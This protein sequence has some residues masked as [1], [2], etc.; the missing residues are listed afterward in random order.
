[1]PKIKVKETMKLVDDQAK[2]AFKVEANDVVEMSDRLANLLMGSGRGE[3][4]VE[5]AVEEAP[6]EESPKKEKGSKK[7]GPI[8]KAEKGPKAKA[9]GDRIT[10]SKS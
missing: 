8:P 3:L 4:Y 7:P 5:E 1:M 9:E 2:P 6:K 10:E